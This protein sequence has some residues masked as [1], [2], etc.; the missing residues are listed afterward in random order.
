MQGQSNSVP[1]LLI[2]DLIDTRAGERIDALARQAGVSLRRYTPSRLPSSL[3][4]VHAA[5]FSREL[6]EGSSLRQPG[7]LSNAFFSL[8]DAAPNLQW[9]HVCSSG[10]DLPQYQPSLQRGVRVTSSRGSTAVP[11]AQTVL[12]AVLA[13]SRGF[14]HW[15][16]AQ[17]QRRW[18]PLR[19]QDMPDDVST[20]RVVVIGAG[21]IGSEI[22]RLLKAVGFHTTAVRRQAVAS[23]HFDET[24]AMSALDTVLPSCHWLVLAL[25]LT[26]DTHG[27][28]DARRLA[29][30]PAHA[31]IVNVARG[32]L[33]DETALVH[34][35][36]QGKLRAAYLDT[37]LEEPLPPASPLWSM[38]NV[39]ISPHNSAASKGH[40]ERVT[41]CFL[42]ELP[43]WLARHA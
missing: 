27:L 10:T 20:Q 30:L 31:G 33:L 39:W 3:N 12:A 1:G 17:Q 8:V 9:L 4:D 13:H 24:V 43:A 18:A 21:A 40:Y 36:S 14:G 28:I 25:P 32:E 38:L 7:P 35:L 22:G 15:L 2:S 5:F 26:S 16:A 19:G 11:I 34:A 41:T 23:D 42:D 29:L 6:Y 37:F